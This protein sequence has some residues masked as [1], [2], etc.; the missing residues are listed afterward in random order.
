VTGRP[1]AARGPG[2]RARRWTGH[3]IHL[4]FS[5]CPARPR[6]AGGRWPASGAAPQG[7]MPRPPPSRWPPSGTVT[8]GRH[9]AR[10]RS[11]PGRVT[12]EPARRRRRRARPAAGP[13]APGRATAAVTRTVGLQEPRVVT[14][15]G[16]RQG[17]QSGP[18]L[19][20]RLAAARRG[21]RP[22]VPGRQSG[23]RDSPSPSRS[24]LDGHSRLP[25][26]PAAGPGRP[27]GGPTQAA[28]P[29]PGSVRRGDRSESDGLFRYVAVVTRPR[30]GSLPGPHD[31]TPTL[32]S[33]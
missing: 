16:A 3:P 23:V 32:H 30:P 10:S 7:R 21:R 20:L 5:V 26:S 8:R 27:G 9:R 6:P 13:A 2:R 24:L 33:G 4:K 19:G 11:P 22:I 15:Y 18:G 28:G 29:G 12:V 1:S 31:I 17:R 25:R 14:A